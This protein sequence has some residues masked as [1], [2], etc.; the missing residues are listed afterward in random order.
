MGWNCPSI[1]GYIGL[2]EHTDLMPNHETAKPYD[3][4]AQSATRGVRQY[5]ALVNLDGAPLTLRE[6]A[7]LIGQLKRDKQNELAE[8]IF[9]LVKKNNQF[10]VWYVSGLSKVH[11]QLDNYLKTKYSDSDLFLKM[12][13]EEIN[14]YD[15]HDFSECICGNCPVHGGGSFKNQKIDEEKAD[16]DM[17]EISEKLNKKLKIAA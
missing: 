12:F 2:S 8:K 6:A 16:K 11:E 5:T 13:K 17:P 7:K 1:C 14:K 15:D 10:K 4:N 9:K 3:P